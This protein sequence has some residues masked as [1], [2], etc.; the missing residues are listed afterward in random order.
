MFKKVD[1]SAFIAGNNYAP[2]LTGDLNDSVLEI[3]IDQ[4]SLLK[5]EFDSKSDSFDQLKEVLPFLWC[6]RKSIEYLFFK[7]NDHCLISQQRLNQS[8]IVSQ[9]EVHSNSEV[10]VLEL[11]IYK[12]SGELSKKELIKILYPLIQNHSE[13]SRIKIFRNSTFEESVEVF[14]THAMLGQFT[15]HFF[16]R[17]R[18]KLT[19]FS[20]VELQHLFSSVELNYIESCYEKDFGGTS[21]NSDIRGIVSNTFKALTVHFVEEINAPQTFKVSVEDIFMR[22]GAENEFDLFPSRPQFEDLPVCSM[23]SEQR[24][25]FDDLISSEGN[26]IIHALGGVG[27]TVTARMFADSIPLHSKAVLFDCFGD[28][29]YRSIHS[30]RHTADK[31][32][33]Q[34]INELAF[35]G[36][37]EPLIARGQ[38]V[39]ELL[40]E[41]TQRV[42]ESVESIKESCP[43]GQLFLFIDAAD[44]AVMAAND[45]SETTP[46]IDLL[47]GF[48]VD[49]CRIICFCR[50]ERRDLLNPREYIKQY[51]LSSFLLD[52]SSEHLKTFFPN[53]TQE[54]AEEFHR[55]SDGNPRVQATAISLHPLSL[56]DMLHNLGPALSSVDQQIEDQLT[57]AVESLK[58]KNVE[59]EAKKVDLICTGLASLPPFIPINV[60]A[61]VTR[62]DELHIKSFIS[63]MGRG[64]ILLDDTL[65]F[66]DEPTESWFRNKFNTTP[67]SALKF[68]NNIK[69]FAEHN[70]YIAEALPFLMARAKQSKELIELALSEAYLPKKNPIDA[71]SIQISRLKFALRVAIKEGYLAEAVKLFMRAAEENAGDQRQLDILE[72]NIELVAHVQEPQEVQKLA[73]KG[74]LSSGWKGSEN[75]FKA[76]LL[77]QV[78]GYK[79][80][81]RSYFRAA[82]NWLRNYF[83]K[84]D[85]S[86]SEHHGN[87]LLVE[88]DISEFF[89]TDYLLNGAENT[90]EGILSWSPKKA[91]HSAVQGFSDRLFNINEK[92]ALVDL[93]TASSRHPYI[94]L[95]FLD[96]M[97]R[98]EVDSPKEVLSDCIEALLNHAE[99]DEADALESVP[100]SLIITFLESCYV[101]DL[102]QNSLTEVFRNYLILIPKLCWENNVRHDFDS[103]WK[104]F[105]K[106]VALKTVIEGA[107]FEIDSFIP[108]D[109]ADKEDR[110]YKENEQLENYKKLVGA[111]VVLEVF[112][113]KVRSN[114]VSCFDEEYGF[115]LSQ[116]KSYYSP[117]YYD[118]A[119]LSRHIEGIQLEIFVRSNQ[120]IAEKVS[121]VQDFIVT[122]EKVPYKTLI[123]QLSLVSRID[124]YHSLTDSFMTKLQEFEKAFKKESPES[125]SEYWVALALSVLPQGEKKASQFL[126]N[127]IEAVSKFGDESLN[128]FMAIL[129]F[130]RS[131]A[132]TDS[133]LGYR[134]AR[135]V[136]VFGE[137][138]GEKY[139]PR[140]D[141][142]NVIHDMDASSS[143]AVLAR[144]LDRDV[145]YMGRVQP[146]LM[147]HAVRSGTLSA[148]SAWASIG[149]LDWDPFAEFL[150]VCLDNTDSFESKEIMFSDAV[151]QSIL[152]GLSKNE[153]KRI[154]K[155]GTK[156]NL[157][158]N[159]LNNAIQSISEESLYK[160]VPDFPVK[161]KEFDWESFFSGSKCSSC[162]DIITLLEKLRSTENTKRESEF[163]TQL[164]SRKNKISAP[165]ILEELLN[166]SFSSE[167]TLDHILEAIPKEWLLDAAIE[168]QWE[169][170]FYKYVE[171]RL[172]LVAN[173]F[174]INW[175]T[176]KYPLEED[177]LLD[178]RA[179][180]VL[181]SLTKTPYPADSESLF[182]FAGILVHLLD[183]KNAQDVL[184]YSLKRFELHIDALDADG[185]WDQNLVPYKSVIKSYC[186]FI[187]SALGNPASEI[188]WQAVHVIHRFV[189]L[190]CVNELGFLFELYSQKSAEAY[191]SESYPYYKFYAQSCFLIG[192]Y[193][194]CNDNPSSLFG[195]K[196]ELLD[197]ALNSEHLVIEKI[198]SDIALK[199]NQANEG[200]YREEQLDCLQSVTKSPFAKK[201]FEKDG[202]FSPSGLKRLSSISFFIDFREYWAKPLAAVFN[203]SVEEVEEVASN[204]VINEW[205]VSVDDRYIEDGRIELWRSPHRKT[206]AKHFS[207]PEEEPYG[208][209]LGYHVLC[210]I[211]SRLLKSIPQADYQS[212][213]TEDISEW[214]LR[215]LP[216]LNRGYLLSD[217]RTPVPLERRRWVEEKHDDDWYWSVNK[218]DFLEGLLTKKDEKT[219]VCVSGYWSDN[220]D[221]KTE[222]F[223]VSSA[224][225]SSS[226]IHN[227]IDALITVDDFHSYK[228][229]DYKDHDFESVKEGFK[230]KG[231]I[232][233]PDNYKRLD[234]VDAHADDIRYPVPFVASEFLDLLGLTYSEIEGS[235]KDTDGCNVGYFENWTEPKDPGYK[236]TEKDVRSG[237]RVY[238]SLHSIQKLC[239]L[240][241][242]S[243]VFEV[244]IQRRQSFSSYRKDVPNEIKYPRAYCNVYSFGPDGVLS[245]QTTS[246][247]LG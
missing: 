47:N 124:K 136:E 67:G 115:A 226:T 133:E 206:Y 103:E 57:K 155:A 154:H 27:K 58:K 99:Q 199:L 77:S 33:V 48:E 25:I 83:Y 151:K 183:D 88:S 146:Y 108:H 132:S 19:G 87:D 50:T 101:N 22:F 28:G 30:P 202:C 80:E 94:C 238:L 31:V 70:S 117:R 171:L 235:Y 175:Y 173:P 107:D 72:N 81:A 210:V 245:D 224:L 239:E 116:S 97:Y 20:I 96:A 207:I 54:N 237:F 137:D 105:V 167:Y 74:L 10:G 98:L 217:L 12:S 109:V 59:D 64:L 4:K 7:S 18:E 201:V 246:Y 152:R 186:A 41:F 121:S 75:L 119:D 84:R 240:T 112:R 227:L 149:F 211:A 36:L 86:S 187:V 192:I 135:C 68:I 46:V 174:W 145:I 189:Q 233:Q 63:E 153:L 241:G 221:S 185:H 168:A 170:V 65:Q 55:L 163:W 229:P 143:F 162:V 181:T 134:F 60:L 52:E 14:L 110:S 123:T 32:F 91:M 85:N 127:A 11:F 164:F 165:D 204:I 215:Y 125:F 216:T 203:V 244:Q 66:R 214:L 35:M 3:S 156:H 184:N 69:E 236:Q 39:N 198:A 161:E 45:V 130:A 128:R 73:F 100:A 222:S 62:I 114:K 43:T 71:R 243:L 79:P 194:G 102:D 144:W 213:E 138:V 118:D 228:V 141:A 148:E 129:S 95:H 93:A 38:P 182:N 76:S 9:I 200:L 126:N 142:L 82:K 219:Y 131:S 2:V 78:D 158:N 16:R 113:I 230:L 179:R 172:D 8:T 34:I 104:T 42:I 234:E 89:F 23:R 53:A 147:K 44:N 159:V 157:S 208:F 21:I 223:R 205:N 37:C 169:G 160:H 242:L 26:M 190:G 176:E 111:T 232:S 150:S 61:L 212:W 191:G 196:D 209:Y 139:F 180:A 177:K 90:I 140:A 51:E 195:F 220:Q 166:C 40:K 24:K 193:R 178:L 218:Q 225:A 5:H 92:Q 15:K 122:N 106:A 120:S 17:K 56:E 247:Q 29:L 6:L 1:R 197:I 188:R 231:W 13:F 49:G